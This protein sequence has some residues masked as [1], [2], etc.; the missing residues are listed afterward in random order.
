MKKLSLACLFVGSLS[1]IACVGEV[2]P[3]SHPSEPGA[4]AGAAGSSGS[5]GASVAGSGGTA[6]SAGS[7]TPP[8]T[9]GTVTP[10]A[11]CPDP[12][13]P[14]VHYISQDPG[15]C[16]ALDFAC[17]DE[18][19]AFDN[20]CGCGCI[21][22][23]GPC[24]ME[25]EAQ[26]K[27]DPSCQPGYKGK[28]DCTCPGPEGYEGANCEQCSPGCF[29]FVA[30]V[31]LKPGCPDPDSSSVHYI[32]QSPKECAVIDFGCKPGQQGF[33]SECGCG[34][35]DTATSCA[36]ENEAQC[37]ADPSCQAGYSGLCDCSCPGG[38]KGYEPG[39]CSG[40]PASCF[41]FAACVPVT[42]GC[43]DP[44]TG[45]VHYLSQDPAQCAA[46][47]FVCSAGQ[48]QFTN[49]CGCGCIDLMD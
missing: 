29:D 28:C 15:K 26:C 7:T 21:D 32:S 14:S 4:S 23:A 35:M 3:E 1:L 45:Y 43:P 36:A 48:E 12:K 9:G 25:N 38:P 10:P 24:A 5:A 41:A 2:T 34:C 40:C 44:E 11:N 16:A 19:K 30:C 17:G 37:K 20:E 49:A 31:P 22:V 42:P 46:M 18:Q 13:S 27:A 6:G 8:G 47:D 39:G 33:D